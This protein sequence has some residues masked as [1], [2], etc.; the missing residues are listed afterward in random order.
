M[1]FVLTADKENEVPWLDTSNRRL[2]PLAFYW[3]A[4]VDLTVP[5]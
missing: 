3:L 4:L 1:K 5:C 2:I